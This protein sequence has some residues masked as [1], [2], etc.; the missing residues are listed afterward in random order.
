MSMYALLRSNKTPPT[1][2]QIEESLAG[3]LCRCTGYRPILDAFQ[4]FAKAMIY[5]TQMVLSRY[6]NLKTVNL[7]ALQ[8]ANP[9]LVDPTKKLLN[10]P[11]FAKMTINP[12]LITK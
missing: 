2:E 12:F 3:N 9:V 5:Y 1:E 6:K 4:V 8:L 10:H 7:F 11:M